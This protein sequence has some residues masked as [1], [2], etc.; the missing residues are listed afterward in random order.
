MNEGQKANP[1]KKI[2]SHLTTMPMPWQS[3]YFLKE[4][5]LSHLK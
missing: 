1:G 3:S 2:R 4:Q 5:D